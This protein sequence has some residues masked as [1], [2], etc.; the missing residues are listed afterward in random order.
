MLP[1]IKIN[2]PQN[3]LCNCLSISFYEY[4]IRGEELLAFLGE[5]NIC[6]STGSACNSSSNEPS[7]V[8]RAIGLS[9]D[10]ANSTLRLSFDYEN[11]IDEADEVI[12]AISEGVMLLSKI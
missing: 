9:E 2:N 6:V 4:G 1:L 10:E 7:H 5:K 11:T 8:L 12:K 3:E